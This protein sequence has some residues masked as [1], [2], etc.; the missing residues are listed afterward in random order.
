[1]GSVSEGTGRRCGV[2]DGY[3][4]EGME[5]SRGQVTKLVR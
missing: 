5:H 2:E 3:V 4:V 1:M